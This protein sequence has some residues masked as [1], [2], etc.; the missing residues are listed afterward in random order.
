MV[1][2]GA[3]VGIALEP[4]L[5]AAQ[6][7][8]HFGVHFIAEHAIHHVRTGVFQ[9]LCPIHIGRFVKARHQFHH[10]SYLLA[11]QRGSHQRAHQIGMAAGAIDGHFDGHH[12]RID[13]G[14]ADKLH[15]RLKRLVRMVQQNIFIARRI[16]YRIAF[17]QTL[18]HTGG[19]GFEFQIGARHHIG[20]GHQA[21]QVYRALH[22]IKLALPQFE[23][24]EQK[25]A[26]MLG[27]GVGHFQAHT[28]AVFAVVQFAL[29][30]GAQVFQVFLIHNQVA[31]AGEA[32]LVAAFHFHTGE[33]A[34]NVFVQ[35][36]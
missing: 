30:G 36:R 3:Q 29:N 13:R 12:I 8:R 21:H 9:L 14:F 24:A 4:A 7:Q 17:T 35:N 34:V 28:V 15:H 26:D 25:V 22:L 27:A 6:H 1:V 5:F 32:E 18:G 10:H 11:G 31:V 20:H 19:I 16:E 33:K 2:A 23:V